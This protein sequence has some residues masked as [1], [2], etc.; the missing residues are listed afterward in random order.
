VLHEEI[1]F[2]HLQVSELQP[3][4]GRL[5]WNAVAGTLAGAVVALSLGALRLRFWWWP[6]HPAGYLVANSWG[7]H[8]FYSAFFVGWLAKTLVTRYGGLRLYRH[9]VPLAIGPI[10]GELMD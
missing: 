8:W 10:G 1:E 5:D 7:M 2:V 9:T 4:A 6:F 3:F